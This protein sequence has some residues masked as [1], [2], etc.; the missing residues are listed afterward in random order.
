[1]KNPQYVV[2][3]IDAAT[4]TFAHV[5]VLGWTADGVPLI[6]DKHGITRADALEEPWRAY[7]VDMKRLRATV[8]AQLL[9]SLAEGDPA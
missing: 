2:M 7:E 6:A 4:G 5:D 9:A 1:V 3:L 8:Q